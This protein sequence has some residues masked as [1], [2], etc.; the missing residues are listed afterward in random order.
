PNAIEVA[1]EPRLLEQ[2]LPQLAE[3]ERRV[4]EC[5]RGGSILGVDAIAAVTRLGAGE[6]SSALM[7]LELKKLVAKRADGSFEART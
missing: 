4:W 3:P 5:F 6:V 1:G 7:M 2:L